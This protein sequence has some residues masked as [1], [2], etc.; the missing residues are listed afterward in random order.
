MQWSNLRGALNN[1]HARVFFNKG[2]EVDWFN[3]TVG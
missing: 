3:M 2:I 1:G